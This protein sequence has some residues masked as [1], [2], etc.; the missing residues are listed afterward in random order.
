MLSKLLKDGSC[1]DFRNSKCGFMAKVGKSILKTHSF[2][3]LDFQNK[4]INC[5]SEDIV[6]MS[7]L[8]L[9]F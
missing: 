6:I 9:D 1:R 7:I 5:S 8:S 4:Y 3:D 2:I